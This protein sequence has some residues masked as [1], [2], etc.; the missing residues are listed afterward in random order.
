[1]MDR[2][3]KRCRHLAGAA[4]VGVC[5]VSGGA[6]LADP[7]LLSGPVSDAGDFS[8][9]QL[10]SM[11]ASTVTVG[12]NSYTGVSLW[13]LLGGTSAGTS[14]VIVSSDKN[15]ILR[16]YIVATGSNGA[17]SLISLGELDPFF[18]GTGQPILVAYQENGNPLSSLQLIVPQDPTGTRDVAGLSGLQ[19]G[20]VP[21]GVS[22]GAATTTQ[23]TLS[24][25]V[26]TPGTYTL[27][28]LASLPASVQTVTYISGKSSKTATY[29]GAS[30]FGLLA[31]A[32]ISQDNILTTYVVAT[33]S[34]GYETVFSLAEL[35][36]AL[37]AP[38]DLLAYS[39]DAGDFV[40]SSSEGLAQ[41]IIPGDNHGGRFVSLLSDLQV[42]DVPEP[43]SGVLLLSALSAMAWLRRRMA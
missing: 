31:A 11:A 26:G 10:E 43:A 6:A 41:I 36:P 1:M 30:F 21:A 23:F 20:G 5:F 22:S 27:S 29:T 34:D 39:D 38:D 12:A 28:D 13:S 7:L 15:A 14:D 33:G 19:I 8:L 40:G 37:G 2:W 4:A 24:G 35:D 25:R 32:G 17:K 42:V 18:G 9:A 16:D 3:V